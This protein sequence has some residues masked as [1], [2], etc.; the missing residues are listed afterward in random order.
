MDL[1][2]DVLDAQLLDRA[3]RKIGRI[4]SIV[5]SL[6][7]DGPP[8]VVAAEAGPVALAARIHPRAAA[9]IAGWL[10]R[11]G[12]V[13]AKPYRIEWASLQR[14]DNDFRID[15]DAQSVPITAGERWT[16]EHVIGRIPGA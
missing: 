5:V 4:D 2:H 14:V 1:I 8:R 12:S 16:R 13:L 6:D 10:Q 3:G 15:V 7:G 9:W 11:R